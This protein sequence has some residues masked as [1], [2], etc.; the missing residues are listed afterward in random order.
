MIQSFMFYIATSF[1]AYFKQGPLGSHGAVKDC[2]N[3]FERAG[4]VEQTSMLTSR[5]RPV[6]KGDPA[7][8]R[9]PPNNSRPPNKHTTPQ[10]QT[11]NFSLQYIID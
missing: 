10:P 5:D 3:G 8:S 11:Y 9:P 4:K 2:S 6:G 1:C 7:V